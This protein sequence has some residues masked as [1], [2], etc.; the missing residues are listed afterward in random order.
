MRYLLAA[1]GSPSSI[2]AARWISTQRVRKVAQRVFDVTRPA[3]A[4]FQGGIHEIQLAGNPA[5]QIIELAD[6]QRVDLIVT[7]TRGHSASTELC[8][9]ST[10]NAVAHT[11]QCPVLIVR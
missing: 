3:L 9:G 2:R 4:G 5:K 10:S 8:L 7:G 11:A 1:D 6:T